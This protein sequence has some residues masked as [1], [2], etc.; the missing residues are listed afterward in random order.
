MENRKID[1][2]I[3]MY[4][5]CESEYKK[6]HIWQKNAKMAYILFLFEK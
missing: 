2:E 6:C 1:K 4:E 5:V 3:C